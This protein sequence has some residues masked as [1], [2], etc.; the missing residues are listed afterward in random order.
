MQTVVTDSARGTHRNY[1]STPRHFNGYEVA[2]KPMR[3]NETSTGYSMAIA[4][5]KITQISSTAKFTRGEDEGKFS[6]EDIAFIP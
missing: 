4:M 6:V 1:L 3:T 5:R 2:T